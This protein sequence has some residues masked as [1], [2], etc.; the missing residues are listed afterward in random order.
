MSKI[1]VLCGGIGCGKSTYASKLAAEGCIV[2]NDD[3]IVKAVHGGDYQKYDKKLSILYKSVE[4]HI[5][6]MAIAAGRDVIIDRAVDIRE[7]AR[8]R[9][10]ALAKSFNCC[11]E[12]VVFPRLQPFECATRRYTSDS[13]GY[14]YEYWLG[15]A[16]AHDKEYV[17]PRMDEGF[18]A[19]IGR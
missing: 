14:S 8:S 12:C 4:N 6:A 9:W 13:R 11:V 3:A 15:V 5:V 16:E 10:V 19:I 1:T 17:A 2:V 18:D 7:Q